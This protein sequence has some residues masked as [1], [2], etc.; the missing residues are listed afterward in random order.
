MYKDN[1]VT[2]VDSVYTPGDCWPECWLISTLSHTVWTSHQTLMYFLSHREKSLHQ[3]IGWICTSHLVVVIQH[4]LHGFF[5]G[6][7]L[8]LLCL[9]MTTQKYHVVN[10]W[11]FT[12]LRYVTSLNAILC[13]NGTAK[14]LQKHY[15]SRTLFLFRR[16]FGIELILHSARWLQSSEKHNY[17]V[18]DGMGLLRFTEM[19]K[20]QF[21]TNW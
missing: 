12:C 1:F 17:N 9:H 14:Y 18:Y 13:S 10:T 8:V 2:C 20:L 4:I 16:I 5:H 7:F 3:K 6:E 15:R 11:M 21:S 19:A